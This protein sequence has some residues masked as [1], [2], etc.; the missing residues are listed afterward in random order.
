M[1]SQ[2]ASSRFLKTTTEGELMTKG[3]KLFHGSAI[4]TKKQLF[5]EP[6]ENNDDVT[7]VRDHGGENKTVK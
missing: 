5:D 6:D 7:S 4:R 1:V 3:D 2:Q